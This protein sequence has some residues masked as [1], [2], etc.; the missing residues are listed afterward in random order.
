MSNAL[1]NWIKEHNGVI[2]EF[3]T[4]EDGDI[5]ITMTHC[6]CWKVRYMDFATI[7]DKLIDTLDDMYLEI[8]EEVGG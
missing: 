3:S 7:H 6:R 8:C 2:V 4:T 5:E 1:F